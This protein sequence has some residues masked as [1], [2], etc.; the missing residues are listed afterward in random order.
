MR[1]PDRGH[2]EP[3]AAAVDAVAL[4][5]SAASPLALVSP[6]ESEAVANAAFR[7]LAA[8]CRWSLCSTDLLAALAGTD[9]EWPT[10]GGTVQEARLER[11]DQVLFV[12]IAPVEGSA[13]YLIEV[14]VQSG[15][16]AGAPSIA[17]SQPDD[18][19]A[20]R[21]ALRAVERCAAKAAER[22]DSAR[23]RVEASL[24]GPDPSGSDREGFAQLVG[25]LAN[26]CDAVAA[27][28]VEAGAAVESASNAADSAGELVAQLGRT[29]DRIGEFS[30]VIA[31]IAQQ[32]NL[33]A[34]NA[35]I[36]AARAGEAGRGFAVVAQEVKS[37]AGETGRATNDI[38]RQV[39]AVQEGTATAA[40][41]LASIVGEIA[42]VRDLQGAVTAGLDRQRESAHSIRRRASEPP[43]NSSDTRALTGELIDLLRDCAGELDSLRASSARLSESLDD[44]WEGLS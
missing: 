39:L 3:L 25:G 34:L 19:G 13:T 42:R 16:P 43:A 28:A 41:A 18:R 27:S 35:T 33:L 7:A 31:G 10:I 6:G 8:R 17:P 12:R 4:V 2:C 40:Q 14:S 44:T 15:G 21:S 23:A 36:E 24:G 30:R 38:G 29:G 26:E 5:R 37:L 32:T 20:W 22:V 11:D 9:V 1:T